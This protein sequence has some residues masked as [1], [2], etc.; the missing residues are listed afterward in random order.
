MR[1]NT[2]QKKA[3]KQVFR[4][5]ERP[6]CVDEVLAYGR[7]LVESLNRATVYRNLKLLINDGWLKRISHPALGALYE[8]TG[9]AHHHHFHCRAC[10]RAFDLPGCAL[11]DDAAP[12]GFVVEDHEIFLFGV[13]P[14]C[15][16]VPQ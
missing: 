4:Q 5:H 3:I 6:L 8:R 16:V 13:C 11:K 14:S 2:T 15:A 12:D 1:R 7:K 10:N 9:R